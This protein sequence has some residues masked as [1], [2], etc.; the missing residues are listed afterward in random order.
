MDLEGRL[1]GADVVRVNDRRDRGVGS[2]AEKEEA[3]DEHDDAEA[4]LEHPP[5]GLGV[6]TLVEQ[7]ESEGPEDVATEGEGE[8]SVARGQ[9]EERRE[10]KL[11]VT[12]P[13][14]NQLSNNEQ[15][16]DSMLMDVTTVGQL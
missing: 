14:P 6:A 15:I 10:R 12:Q 4:G 8:V 2:S 16:K 7:P 13:H 1:D 3:D 11:S 5:L 9:L